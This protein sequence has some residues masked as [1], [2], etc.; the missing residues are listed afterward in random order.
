MSMLETPKDRHEAI[1]MIARVAIEYPWRVKAFIEAAEKLGL[2]LVPAAALDPFLAM[3]KACEHLHDN[4]TIAARA[5]PGNRVVSI[6]AK[7]FHALS[8]FSGSAA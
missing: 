4:E 2:R 5:V 6:D 8:E 7:A 3:A 1:E